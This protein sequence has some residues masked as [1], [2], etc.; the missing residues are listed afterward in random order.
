MKTDNKFTNSL[1][2]DIVAGYVAQPE[3]IEVTSEQ[4]DNIVV[5][6][7][8]VD[9]GDY[10]KVVGAS[11]KNWK[12]LQT[13]VRHI[14]LSQGRLIKIILQ[15]PTRE[16][17]GR[18]STKP[19]D[20]PDWSVEATIDLLKEVVGIIMAEKQEVAVAIHGRSVSVL[21]NTTMQYPPECELAQAL[22]T[23]FHASAKAHGV[24]LTV[25]FMPGL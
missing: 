4:T 8:K 11:G 10:G 22:N 5:V 2:G 6:T 16:W 17:S 21:V 3:Q 20:D 13:V 14:G 7:I 9:D 19:L 24:I 1:I 23:I 18:A 15:E 12:A 25:D